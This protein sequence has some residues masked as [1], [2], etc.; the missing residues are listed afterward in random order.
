MQAGLLLDRV[1][2]GAL[3]IKVQLLVWVTFVLLIPRGA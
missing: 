3:M 2:A 1:E